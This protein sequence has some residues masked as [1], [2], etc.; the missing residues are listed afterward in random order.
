MDLNKV[1]DE[2]EYHKKSQF[3]KKHLFWD[4][5]IDFPFKWIPEELKRKIR[6]EIAR[7]CA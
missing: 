2:M 4:G 6:S 3:L 7:N 1:W 5:L